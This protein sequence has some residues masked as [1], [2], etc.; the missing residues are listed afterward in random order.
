MRQDL[1]GKPQAQ[2][3]RVG[4][5]AAPSFEKRLPESRGWSLM[6]SRSPPANLTHDCS[7]FSKAAAPG[8]T[9]PPHPS[10][11][12]ITTTPRAL[13]TVC[14]PRTTVHGSGQ[15]RAQNP[16]L[17]SQSGSQAWSSG[18][19]HSTAPLSSRPPLFPL[20]SSHR[21]PP[22]SSMSPDPLRP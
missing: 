13:H 10:S 22:C 3:A 17:I 18:R 12:S 8:W 6:L 21:L 19:S 15:C 4:R 11:S 5:G 16:P 14:I 2:G 20:P 1:R 7:V 9:R